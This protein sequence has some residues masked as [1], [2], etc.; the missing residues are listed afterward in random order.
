MRFYKIKIAKTKEEKIAVLKFR[1]QIYC[2]ELSY[3]FLNKQISKD[4]LLCDEFDFTA[5][6]II[7]YSGDIKDISGTIRFTTW[8]NNFP[9][10]I[11]EK[12]KIT[13]AILAQIKS[14]GEI[15][16][17]Q[18]KDD[19]RKGLLGLAL[20][21]ALYKINGDY[22]DMVNDLTFCD[23][24]PGLISK[25]LKFGAFAY[26][27][28]FIYE[29]MGILQIPLAIATFDLQF[30]RRE[31]CFTYYIAKHNFKKYQR[32]LSSKARVKPKTYIDLIP[33]Y[34]LIF[35]PQ[36]ITFYR[37][38]IA[39]EKFKHY[40]DD[41]IRLLRKVIVIPIM[42]NIPLIKRDII[43]YDL[44]L[45][46]EG[47]LGVYINGKLIATLHPGN[48]LGEMA[49]LD[50]QHKR[51]ADVITLTESKILIIPR[52]FLNYLKRRNPQAANE[53][54]SL[55]ARCLLDKLITAN[56][57]ISLMSKD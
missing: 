2:Q 29:E 28:S 11:I 44:Y 15:R 18:V 34:Q 55:I 9:K 50:K 26:S 51:H 21:F 31:K 52:N 16:F 7:L 25:Y 49:F 1:Y 38:N 35:K 3:Q 24:M 33:H 4:N 57:V 54:L 43:D 42:P 5:N 32:K 19:Y 30:L 27:K 37:D 20:M 39:N 6:T 14:I 8:K 47:K 23:C 48:I 22:V 45:L 10:K 13:D 53:L 56:H 12:Y 17:L 40:F 36:Q 46:L 41:I